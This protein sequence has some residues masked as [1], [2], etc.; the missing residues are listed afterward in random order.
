MVVARPGVVLNGDRLPQA[1]S[2][3]WPSVG[4]IG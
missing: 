4:L 2:G 3:G 1:V